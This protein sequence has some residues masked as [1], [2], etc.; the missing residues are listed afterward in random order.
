[1]KA[2]RIVVVNKID[3]PQARPTEVVDEIFNLFIDL[4]NQI[5]FVQTKKQPGVMED[6]FIWNQESCI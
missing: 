3:R 1:M 6:A 4:G 2:A 5:T